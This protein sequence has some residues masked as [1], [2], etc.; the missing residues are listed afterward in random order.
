MTIIGKKID[1]K[2]VNEVALD[3]GIILK[4]ERVKGGWFVTHINRKPRAELDALLVF[5]A[6]LYSNA[7]GEASD[8][9]II[10][11]ARELNFLPAVSVG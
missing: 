1:G 5:Y 11:R 9:Y 10:D 6:D 3:S 7:H 4:M 8:E 2:Q